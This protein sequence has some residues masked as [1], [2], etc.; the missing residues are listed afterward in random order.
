MVISEKP[1]PVCVCPLPL[2][3]TALRMKLNI[4]PNLVVLDEMITAPNLY[5][6]LAVMV[7]SVVVDI[8]MV[9]VVRIENPAPRAF[10][11][12]AV[13]DCD[14]SARN[15]ESPPSRLV[16]IIRIDFESIDCDV[17]STD[18]KSL[19]SDSISWTHLVDDFIA[20][21]TTGRF[22]YPFIIGAT[23]DDN[24]VTGDHCVCC[25]LDRS[26]WQDFRTWLGIVSVYVVY[27]IN[28]SSFYIY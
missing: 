25:L 1:H 15:I 22:A 10:G 23:L 20:K 3:R 14:I 17:A 11:Y 18:G 27:I 5:P 7:A 19:A 9:R 2:S 13:L 16:I 12:E 24:F 6:I 21:A 28:F 26:P 4:L 8:S